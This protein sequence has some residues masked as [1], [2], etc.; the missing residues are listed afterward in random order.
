MGGFL[1]HGICG[2]IDDFD[3]WGSR[4]ALT[5]HLGSCHP[6]PA[7][8]SSPL[9]SR[10]KSGHSVVQRPSMHCAVQLTPLMLSPRRQSPEYVQI[11]AGDWVQASWPLGATPHGQSGGLGAGRPRQRAAASREP[12][13]APASRIAAST[14]RADSSALQAAAMTTSNRNHDC[15]RISVCCL[16]STPSSSSRGAGANRVR[17]RRLVIGI[18]HG[19]TDAAVGESNAGGPGLPDACVD[20]PLAQRLEADGA[21]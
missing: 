3:R 9:F 11:V 5:T 13:S 20:K 4:A 18:E 6:L 2:R 14:L 17:S 12:E 10:Q 15:K 1:M 8:L 7:S 21:P 19:P 16:M